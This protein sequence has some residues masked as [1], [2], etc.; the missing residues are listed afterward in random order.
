MNPRIVAVLRCGC[1]DKREGETVLGTV[2]ELNAGGDIL[3]NEYD[4]ERICPRLQQL[5]VQPL[6]LVSASLK[7]LWGD[8]SGAQ[9]APT[10]SLELRAARREGCLRPAPNGCSHLHRRHA[11]LQPDGPE[12]AV[13]VDGR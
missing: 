13:A 12:A 8:A 7:R 3:L 10:V 2:R 1:E 5:A 6:S 11:D 4:T 9:Q